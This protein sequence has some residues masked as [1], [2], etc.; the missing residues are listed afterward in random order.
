MKNPFSF[1]FL[2]NFFLRS[3]YIFL[4]AGIVRMSMYK[5]NEANSQSA[6]IPAIQHKYDE[7]QYCLFSTLFAR[8]PFL[9]P[10]IQLFHWAVLLLH[11]RL[12][13]SCLRSSYCYRRQQS[14][15]YRPH[16]PQLGSPSGHKPLFHIAN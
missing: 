10:F 16:N 13:L 8:Y 1:N 15:V 12:D 5:L 2:I 14:D 7:N 3:L 9:I 11:V 6:K 4:C